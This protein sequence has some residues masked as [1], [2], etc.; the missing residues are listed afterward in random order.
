MNIKYFDKSKGIISEISEN[1]ITVPF[2]GDKG[3]S[4]YYV[5]NGESILIE[6]NKKD[7]KY[8][9]DVCGIEFSM[10]HT[11]N[12]NMLS[13]EVIIKNNTDKEFIPDAIGLK[14]GI[15]SYM[16]EYPYWNDKFFLD[17]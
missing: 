17:I 3:P 15:D 14:L 7:D 5:K 13:A 9:K 16:T 12:D 1:G 8:I 10:K 6:L 4:L 11:V 2:Y